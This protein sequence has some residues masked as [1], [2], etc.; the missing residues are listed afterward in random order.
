[1]SDCSN[2]SLPSDP[3]AYGNQVLLLLLPLLA[4]ILFGAAYIPTY[5]NSHLQQQ[6]A[7]SS[8]LLLQLLLS[9]I[10]TALITASKLSFL[11]AFVNY[12]IYTSIHILANSKSS[13]IRNNFNLYLRYNILTRNVQQS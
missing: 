3:F 12:K 10:I 9:L 5:K 13:I 1:M 4:M 2:N 6:H 8:N 7:F 11:N